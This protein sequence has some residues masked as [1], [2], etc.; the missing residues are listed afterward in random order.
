M[1]RECF[2]ALAMVGALAACQTDSK[3][4]ARMSHADMQ[5]LAGEIAGRCLGT[6]AKKDTPAMD[7]CIRRETR[8]EVA[9]RFR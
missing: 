6:G 1:I 7:A 3:P 2:A 5:Q 9:A 8:K 4:S